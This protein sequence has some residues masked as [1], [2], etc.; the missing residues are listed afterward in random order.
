MSKVRGAKNLGVSNPQGV[1][2]SGASPPGECLTDRSPAVCSRNLERCDTRG[3]S[4]DQASNTIGYY[5]NVFEESRKRDRQLK[6]VGKRGRK[7]QAV[8]QLRTVLRHVAD[9]VG[10][11]FDQLRDSSPEVLERFEPKFKEFLCRQNKSKRIRRNYPSALRQFLND[12]SVTSAPITR[13][14]RLVTKLSSEW[15]EFRDTVK[16]RLRAYDL[17]NFTI[18]AAWASSRSLAPKNLAEGIRP[19][20]FKEWISKETVRDPRRVY[21]GVRVALRCLGNVDGYPAIHLDP[22]PQGRKERFRLPMK[23]WPERI[24]NG[25]LPILIDWES[26]TRATQKHSG[27]YSTDTVSTYLAMLERY[28]GWLS[29]KPGIGLAGLDFKE[30]WRF[31]WIREFAEWNRRRIAKRD[32]DLDPSSVL[33]TEVENPT[34]T[35]TLWYAFVGPLLEYDLGMPIEVVKAVRA[36]WRASK[37]TLRTVRDK[38]SKLVP[39]TRL[40][41]LLD[42]MCASRKE[43][44]RAFLKAARAEGFQIADLEKP[45]SP[46]ASR[47]AISRPSSKRLL[48]LW[49]RC[50]K[51]VSDE[52]LLQ[53][54]R[55][56]PLRSRNFRETR[57]GTNLL[58]NEDGSWTFRFDRTQM[59]RLQ[60]GVKKWEASV[61]AWICDLMDYYHQVY[62]PY[63][64]ENPKSTFAFLDGRGHPLI[65]A[66][67]EERRPK[68]GSYIY[69]LVTKLSRQI[70]GKKINPHL[71]R[72]IVILEILEKTGGNVVLAAYLIGDT[73]ETTLKAYTRWTASKSA[74]KM[75]AIWEAGRH[76]VDSSR[77]AD[78]FQLLKVLLE[79]VLKL[80]ENKRTAVLRAIGGKIDEVREVLR[81]LA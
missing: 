71:F 67:S 32:R 15:A 54:M 43:M 34:P 41:E 55:F 81:A 63:Y 37:A 22:L 11:T 12:I 58:R 66:S 80:P 72:D 23:E 20:E 46:E 10:V 44:E 29:R 42:Q 76:G 69:W 25:F 61:P 19:A 13:A 78:Q 31:E 73:V 1:G 16:P 4:S 45:L 50:A 52:L 33:E 77:I 8:Y 5:F 48:R 39:A 26:P 27:R 57:F 47:W 17:C 74:T 68:K 28:V 79:P 18:L 35:V 7:D 2:S 30:L 62:W 56:R 38:D 36:A 59:K 21:N 3:K 40:D 9:G 60:R 49:R 14:A 70:L 6:L 75:D 24:R 64:R 53:L 65:A 51:A